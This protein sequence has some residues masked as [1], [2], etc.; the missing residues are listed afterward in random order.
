MTEDAP[1]TTRQ[2]HRAGEAVTVVFCNGMGMPLELWQPV[3]DRLPDDYA[4]V[5]YDRPAAATR[6]ADDLDEQV[7]E[8]DDVLAAAQADGIDTGRLILVGHSYGGVLAEAYA[9]LRPRRVAGLVLADAAVPA[10]YA[11]VVADNDGG[12]ELPWWRNAAITLSDVAALRP[13]LSWLFSAGMVAT[14]TR[15][16]T[17]TDAVKALPPGAA[18]RIVSADNVTRAMTDDHWLPQI[19][20]SLLDDRERSGPLRIPTIILV[21]ASGPRAWP[22]TPNSWVTA[23][24][25]Q[26]RDISTRASVQDLPGAHLLMLDVPDA[27]AAAIVDVAAA[28]EPTQV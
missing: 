25:A 1:E 6:R 26:A 7:G 12:G 24:R 22:S 20:A 9:R 5:R 15:Q 3:V 8:I 2:E 23:Q 17:F 14:A 21:G 11:G 4:V 10:E 18:T 27:V 16:Q 13:V 28:I 19:C